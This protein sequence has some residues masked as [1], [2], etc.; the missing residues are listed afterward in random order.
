LSSLSGLQVGLTHL[1]ASLCQ[2]ARHGFHDLTNLRLD[3][4]FDALRHEVCDEFTH[5]HII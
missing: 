3:R 5:R 4:D 2:E 1:L